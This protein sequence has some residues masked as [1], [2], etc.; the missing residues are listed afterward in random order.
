MA[1]PKSPEGN[2]GSD[3]DHP[4]SCPVKKTESKSCPVDNKSTTSTPPT[5]HPE[6]D[7]SQCPVM[8]DQDKSQGLLGDYLGLED[9]KEEVKEEVCM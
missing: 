1:S 3:V 4:V 2:T 5:T 6:G 7:I 9:K 8:H